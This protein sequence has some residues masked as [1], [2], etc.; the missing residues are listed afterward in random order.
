[1]RAIVLCC[2]ASGWC[3]PRDLHAFLA[4]HGYVRIADYNRH[5]THQDVIYVHHGERPA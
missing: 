2:P 5:P 3:D 4:D 1:M